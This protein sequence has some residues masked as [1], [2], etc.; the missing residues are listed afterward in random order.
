M[1]PVLFLSFLTASPFV[2]LPLRTAVWF[3]FLDLFFFFLSGGFLFVV[4]VSGVVVRRRGFSSF[5]L[6]LNWMR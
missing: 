3:W 4:W 2:D 6:F 5:F 1:V